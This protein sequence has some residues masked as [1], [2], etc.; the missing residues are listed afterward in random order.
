MCRAQRRHSVNN[1]G[2][3]MVFEDFFGWVESDAG[4]FASQAVDDIQMA[5]T[6]ASIDLNNRKI[7]WTDGERLSIDQSATKIKSISTVDIKILKDHIVLW[8]EMDFVPENLNQKE[9]VIFE[10]KINQWI[11]DYKSGVQKL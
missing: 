8:L 4:E 10:K 7:V 6:G 11:K 5:L 1:K 2:A 9:M 3:L